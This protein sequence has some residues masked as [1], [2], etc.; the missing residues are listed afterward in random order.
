[1]DSPHPAHGRGL[2]SFAAAVLAL[3]LLVCAAPG[4]SA[5]ARAEDPTNETDVVD[6]D[7]TQ[8]DV[9]EPAAVE[10]QVPELVV[11]P[12]D[13]LFEDTGTEYSVSILVRNP[14]D[15]PVPAGTLRLEI[16]QQ[17][18]KTLAELGSEDPSA[19]HLLA[20]SELRETKSRDAQTV[21][22]TVR[23]ADMPLTAL[24]EPG[25]YQL[26]ATFVPEDEPEEPAASRTPDHPATD[27]LI[28][29]ST[30]VVWQGTAGAKV[31][32]SVIVPLVLPSDIDTLP[33]PDQLK[34][35][36]PGLN[37]LL[38]TATAQRATLAID[39][40]IIASIRAYGE[41]APE[42]A[43]RFLT[44]LESSSLQSFL[45]QF[46][47]ADPAAQAALGFPKLLEPTSLDFASRLGEFPALDTEEEPSAPETTIPGAEI[48]ADPEQAADADNPASAADG[49][50]DSDVPSDSSSTLP[51]LRELLSWPKGTATAWPAEGAVDAATLALLRTSGITTVVLDSENVWQED[52]P[53]TTLSDTSALITDAG[54]GE[55]TRAALTAPTDTEKA[56]ALATAASRL[57]LAAQN[58]SPGIII[59]LDR[60]ATADSE[61]PEQMLE[62]LA[63][64]SWVSPSSQTDL[65]T[66][67]AVL[68]SAETLED[69]RELLR[70]AAGREDS[71]DEVGAILVHPEYLTGYQRTRLLELFATR[72]AAPDTDFASVAADFKKR[73]TEL[74]RG[75]EAISTQ[76][77]QLVG[78]STRVPVQ[79]R[80]SLPFEALV[81]VQVV[82]ASAALSVSE[83]TFSNVSVRADGNER[84][85]VP[86][87]SRVSS[88]ESGLVV[89]IS[90]ADDQVTVFTGTL[91]I[92]ISSVIE[93]IALWTLG[94]LAALLLSFGIWRS[95]RRRRH[96]VS[97]E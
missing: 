41:N 46:A 57:A 37:R 2:R 61:N 83:P 4:A 94:V 73:D 7:T 3:M 33:T 18:T 34:D 81:K 29:S 19:R 43:R 48:D 66:A 55:A 71:V 44:R 80:N 20:E 65:P 35:V 28:S 14:S 16:D 32:V 26:H 82:P 42:E 51:K 64:L 40:R 62:A 93:S 86:V 45:L 96:A 24:S 58:N 74:M 76:R 78:V 9:D 91:A 84:L 67:P 90:S 38:V 27:E 36:V 11:A 23:R 21:D 30:P 31:N 15:S 5:V 53:R 13:P 49:L 59:G 8:S 50:P 54:L 88:G 22:F 47:D 6:P 39:P 85:L 79:L 89:T 92:S 87:R 17:R 68:K 63:T 69:R 12:E 56:A 10:E 77:T 95:V 25:V 1:M 70:T 72:Y 75:V 60:G 52:T 97:G